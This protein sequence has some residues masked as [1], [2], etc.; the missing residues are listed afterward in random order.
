MWMEDITSVSGS[1]CTDQHSLYRTAFKFESH[2]V[3]L[4]S[5]L[6]GAVRIFWLSSALNT[7]KKA[8][9]SVHQDRDGQDEAEVSLQNVPS[10]QHRLSALQ[11]DQSQFEVLRW[12]LS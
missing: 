1:P 2:T 8:E 9:L 4:T 12:K 6:V 7:V 10:N 3:S 11:A 5:L